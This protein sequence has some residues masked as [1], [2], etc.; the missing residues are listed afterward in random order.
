[1]SDERSGP[2]VPSVVS[3]GRPRSNWIPLP[4]QRIISMLVGAA[5]L[6]LV[7][8]LV[9]SAW[10]RVTG[11]ADQPGGSLRPQVNLALFV[12]NLVVLGSVLLS[13]R[14][15]NGQRVIAYA[16]GYAVIVWLLWPLMRIMPENALLLVLSLVAYAGLLGHPWLVGYLYL[17]LL[18]QRF[19]PA[20]LYSAF[21]LAALFYTTLPPAVR[22]WHHGRERFVPLC[23]LAGM[24]FLLLLLLPI[25]YF[26]TLTSAQDIHARLKEA[27][28]LSALAVSLRTSAIAAAVVMLFGVP[29]A[30]AMVRRCFPGRALIDSLIDLPI[31]LPPPIAGITLLFFLGPKTPL[32]R[33]LDQHFGLQFFDS[34]W[35]IIAAQVFVGSPFL[36]RASMVAFE[37][38]DVRYEKVART[39]GASTVSAFLR[40]TLPMSV[41][42]ILIGTI[43][44]WFRAMAEF[45]SLRVL[46]N[47][48]RTI[49]VLAYER[50]IEFRQS[51]SQSVAVL[52]L[53][54][55]LG[56]IVGMW[57]IRA[58]PRLLGRAIGAANAAR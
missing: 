46:A 21:L 57:I 58:M 47:R 7:H 51:E 4:R 52:V 12:A 37:A 43:L 32:G 53:L 9:G 18:S 10:A 33:F 31:V 17:F 19:M 6:A 56:V 16:V 20:Y 15:L 26:C 5:I 36:I 39:L 24:M 14:S 49:P 28:V 45:G 35:G 2:V 48:P 30:Y 25:V 42:G 13:H 38:V 50:F 11:S 27:D 41:R 40:V 29:L 22:A 44:T 8:L 23:H 55:S 1:M 34:E 3:V 54:L